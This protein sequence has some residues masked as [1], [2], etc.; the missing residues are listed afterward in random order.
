[1]TWLLRVLLIPSDQNKPMTAQSHLPIHYVLIFKK[2][3][4]HKPSGM[5]G[6]TVEVIINLTN[7]IANFYNET[8]E[9]HLLPR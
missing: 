5:D 3:I 2:N 1:M 9:L 4:F 6:K 8:G 7:Y